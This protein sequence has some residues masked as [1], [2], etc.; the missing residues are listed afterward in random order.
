MRTCVSEPSRENKNLLPQS[1]TVR[2][3][4]PRKPLPSPDPFPF[5]NLT[6]RHPPSAYPISALVF[7]TA[8]GA[9]PSAFTSTS[10]SPGTVARTESPETV[11]V[12]T[13]ERRAWA[14]RRPARRR[15]ARRPARRRRARRPTTR[16][17]RA[18]RRRGAAAGAA[19]EPCSC[20]RG[21]GNG[22]SAETTNRTAPSGNSVRIS[23]C[24]GETGSGVLTPWASRSAS[25]SSNL[26]DCG[27]S[28]SGRRGARQA[29]GWRGEGGAVRRGTARLQLGA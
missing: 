17:R 15:R 6:P 8:T 9:A 13:G 21:G 1:G 18:R 10:F 26:P 14:H 29:V 24:G 7:C 3:K 23:A 19:A 28:C 27:V 5:P 12:G 11:G 25:F 4:P 16:R 2:A 20:W 22:T